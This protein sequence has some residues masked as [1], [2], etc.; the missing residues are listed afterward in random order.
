MIKLYVDG[1]TRGSII[2]L[3]DPQKNKNIVKKR[4]GVQGNELTNNELEYLAVIYGIEYAK[5]NYPRKKI[6][7]ISDS[8]LIVNHISGKFKCNHVNLKKLLD[9]T[10]NKMSEDI[11]VRW[12][13]RSRNLAGVH[14]ET[15]Y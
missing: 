10:K 6:L 7:I 12:V 9:R 11:I 13:P 15:F 14:L 8:Q 4:H 2:C 5:N 1:G 3:H